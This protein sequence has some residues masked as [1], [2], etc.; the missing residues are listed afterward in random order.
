MGGYR[1]SRVGELWDTPNIGR[2]ESLS[3]TS[4]GVQISRAESLAWARGKRGCWP[5]DSGE[6]RVS[7]ADAAIDGC[8][9]GEFAIDAT[10][11]CFLYNKESA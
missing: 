9:V 1:S 2:S 4:H 6:L 3:A 10:S 8:S 5:L 11:H 7:G